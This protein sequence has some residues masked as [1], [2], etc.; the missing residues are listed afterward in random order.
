MLGGAPV[1]GLGAGRVN[2]NTLPCPSALRTSTLP[3]WASIAIWTK[4]QAEAAGGAAPG[5]FELA[6][7][8]EDAP[9]MFGRD[10]RAIVANL[11]AEGNVH[12][13]TATVNLRALPTRLQITRRMI[14]A[15]KNRRTG[16]RQGMLVRSRPVKLM[17]RLAYVFRKKS[18]W[19]AAGALRRVRAA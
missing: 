2:Q 7:F 19:P 18:R 12:L 9:V 11:G 16:C 5:V 8:F 4:G 15:S 14:S 6:E 13:A 17:S 1:S 3:T 10:A